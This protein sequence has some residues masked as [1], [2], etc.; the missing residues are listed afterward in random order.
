M[1][2]LMEN[3][4]RFVNEEE[5]AV[6]EERETPS[7][8]SHASRTGFYKSYE[9]LVAK[10]KFNVE[11]DIIDAG[12]EKQ[13]RGYLASIFDDITDKQDPFPKEQI[14]ALTQ[15]FSAAQPVIKGIAYQIGNDARYSDDKEKQRT[16]MKAILAMLG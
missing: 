11:K 2:T 5:E 4:N 10:G 16:A 8:W 6:N 7:W 14:V 13:F 1:K 9:D 15:K 3:W 12:A